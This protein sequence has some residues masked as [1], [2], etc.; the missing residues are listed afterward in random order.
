MLHLND[1]PVTLKTVLSVPFH[2]V[3]IHSHLGAIYQQWLNNAENNL[4]SIHATIYD[5]SSLYML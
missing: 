1:T 2:N 3:A 5:P 4:L